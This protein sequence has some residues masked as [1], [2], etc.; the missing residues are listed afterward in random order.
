MYFSKIE[1]IKGTFAIDSQYRKGKKVYVIY[2]I[3]TDNLYK[4]VFP[5]IVFVTVTAAIN[6]IEKYY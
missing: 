4:P 1:T 5:G 3:I 2:R 6:A